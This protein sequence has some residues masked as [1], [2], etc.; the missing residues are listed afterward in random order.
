ME[1]FT[2][3]GS[4]DDTLH[5][6]SV[7]GGEA[8]SLV[9]TQTISVFM[10]AKNGVLVNGFDLVVPGFRYGTEEHRFDATMERAGFLGPGRTVSTTMGARFVQLTFGLTLDLHVLTLPLPRYEITRERARHLQTD[11]ASAVPPTRMP[12]MARPVDR[13]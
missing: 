13:R 10:Y 4:F 3:V 11:A 12:P 6:L 5:R 7:G 1:H 9:Y 8:L 2:T